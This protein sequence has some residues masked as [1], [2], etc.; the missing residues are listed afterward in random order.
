MGCTIPLKAYRRRCLVLFLWPLNQAGPGSNPGMGGAGAFAFW[1][2]HESCYR[3]WCLVSASQPN[4]AG[5]RLR[6]RAQHTRGRGYSFDIQG[7]L[8]LVPMRPWRALFAGV[9][10][11]HPLR[12]LALQRVAWDHTLSSNVAELLL[13]IRQS[14]Q[15]S[16][17]LSSLAQ[18][19][20]HLLV[21]SHANK[22]IER[23]FANVIATVTVPD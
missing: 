22:R 21:A 10:L 1:A 13:S 5:P 9:S 14:V 4:Q 15:K 2:P 18:N 16:Q 8:S 20:S 7:R 11:E 17:F 3:H 12:W 19:A 6:Y 23:H